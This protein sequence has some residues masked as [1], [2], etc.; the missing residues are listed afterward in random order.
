[1]EES[2]LSNKKFQYFIKIATALSFTLFLIYQVVLTVQI[3]TN[4]VGRLIGIGF[5]LL[6]TV[7]SYLSFSEKYSVWIAH[8]V[9][10]VAGLV[11]LF[12]MRLFNLSAFIEQLDFSNL[13]SVLNFL[14]Y[15]LPQIGTL[16]LVAGY[17]ALRADLE[18]RTIQI[19]ETVLMTVAIVLYVLTFIIECVLI[20][21]YR[22]NVDVSRKLTLLSRL[23]Y[24]MGYVGTAISFTLPAPQKEEKVQESEFFYSDNDDDEIDLIL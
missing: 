1:M 16:V 12:S 18:N 20:I 11:M 10:F 23:L 19:L 9:L 3:D 17:L 24:C 14:S 6:L 5:Y 8:S 15:I 13:P 2:R 7:A 4:R 22:I 21:V